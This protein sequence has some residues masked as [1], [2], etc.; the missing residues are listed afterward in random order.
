M[1]GN[2]GILERG[3]EGR[4]IEVSSEVKGIGIEV[5][6]VMRKRGCQRKD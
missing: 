2:Q 3:Q 6:G 1:V 5:K 4:G